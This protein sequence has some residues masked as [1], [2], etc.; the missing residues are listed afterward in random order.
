MA[1]RHF[2]FRPVGKYAGA[3]SV[4]MPV[5]LINGLNSHDQM[6]EFSSDQRNPSL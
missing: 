5:L 1:G 6:G 4:A 2:E 3:A